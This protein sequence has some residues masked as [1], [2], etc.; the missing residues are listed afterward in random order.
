MHPLWLPG[1]AIAN[2]ICLHRC[3]HRAHGRSGNDSRGAPKR[4][5][6]ATSA[7]LASGRPC[8]P[9]PSRAFPSRMAQG[10]T[11]RQASPRRARSR[12]CWPCPAA[13]PARRRQETTGNDDLPRRQA[14][15][16]ATARQQPR[17][18]ASRPSAAGIS[19]HARASLAGSDGCRRGG[20]LQAGSA[21]RPP[22]ATGLA[23]AAH[24]A[25][26]R[27]AEAA[28]AEPALGAAVVGS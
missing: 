3:M 19:C 9:L 21:S 10:R 24:D 2:A 1:K 14:R 11:R 12:R 5:P 22:R 25:M 15:F 28:R 20:R 6:R 7:P 23:R 17:F 4:R 13:R 27:L 18:P 16:P 8:A 26:P